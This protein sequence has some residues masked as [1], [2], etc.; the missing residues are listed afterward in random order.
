MSGHLDVVKLLVYEKA[1]INAQSDGGG[2]ALTR[3]SIYGYIDIVKFLVE[4]G[5]D[6]N[7]RDGYWVNAYD[8][9]HEAGQNETAEL[10]NHPTASSG[11]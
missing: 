5:A 8:C 2:T 1:D 10:I 7:A 6:V 3:A 11:V 9:A 4:N